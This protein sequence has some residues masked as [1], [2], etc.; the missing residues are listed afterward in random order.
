MGPFFLT[1][2]LVGGERNPNG[3][4]HWIRGKAEKPRGTAGASHPVAQGSI[5]GVPG[6]LFDIAKTFWL[7]CLEESGQRLR[8]S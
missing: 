4:F 8:N 2:I 5:L 1:L 3:K 6:N 7:R